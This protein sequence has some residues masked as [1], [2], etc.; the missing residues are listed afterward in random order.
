MDHLPLTLERYAEIQAKLDAGALL[1][2][3]LAGERLSEK[4]W[5]AA[6]NG[7]LARMGEEV[8]CGRFVINLAYQKAYLAHANLM[9]EPPDET[10]S[11]DA[12]GVA[13]N[14]DWGEGLPFFDDPNVEPPTSA[15]LS[16]P[17]PPQALDDVNQTAA[18]NQGIPCVTLPFNVVPEQAAPSP[19]EQA[20][21]SAPPPAAPPP[22]SASHDEHEAGV[23]QTAFAPALTAAD[24]LSPLPFEQPPASRPPPSASALTLEQYASYCV[25]R[26]HAGPDQL[27][28]VDTRYGIADPASRAALDAMW[29]ARCAAEPALRHRLMQLGAA[30]RQW[31]ESR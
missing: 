27:A 13:L 4:V 1:D 22:P 14:I 10:A 11:I 24:L 25:E 8:L 3:L 15:T 12:T 9:P 6:R 18:E 2:E 19:P 21:I 5:D 30:Y 7:W 16:E 23:D 28:L 29:E 31:L 26:E 20:P 17:E